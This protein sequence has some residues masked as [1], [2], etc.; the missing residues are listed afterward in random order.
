MEWYFAS[1]RRHKEFI[2]KIV[3]FLESQNHSVVYEWSKL[4]RLKPYHK[5]SDKSSLV[6]REIGNALKD[7]DI[8]VLISDEAGT[9]MFIELGIV[10]REWM[11]NKKIKIYIVGKFNDR[12]LMHHHPSIKRVNKIRDVFSIECPEILN[13]RDLS[14]L[15]DSYN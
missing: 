12:S 4:G 2:D 11:Q 3:N 9:D 14:S 13:N 7:V 10:I 15:I 6:A 8:F 1:R 5:N